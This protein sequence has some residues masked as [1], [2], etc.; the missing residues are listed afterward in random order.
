MLLPHVAYMDLKMSKSL[1]QKQKSA[2]YGFK[3]FFF[4]G[5]RKNK[6]SLPFNIMVYLKTTD[7]IMFL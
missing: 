7:A 5:R 4:K 3:P 6:C 2:G 1:L